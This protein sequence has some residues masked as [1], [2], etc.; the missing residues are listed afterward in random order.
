MTKIQ[1]LEN[2]IEQ[3]MEDYKKD[4]DSE[5]AKLVET[6]MEEL[7]DIYKVLEKLNK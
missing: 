5:I 2:E 3:L 1:K 6:K 4:Y 7:K